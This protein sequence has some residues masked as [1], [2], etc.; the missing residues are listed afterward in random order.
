MVLHLAVSVLH[1]GELQAGW[2]PAGRLHWL[3]C[4]HPT[5]AP[6]PSQTPGEPP[7]NVHDRFA[8]AGALL[9]LL[10]AAL[11]ITLVQLLSAPAGK[12]HWLSWLQATQVPLLLQNPGV[13]LPV[14]AHP[15]F[16][17]AGTT[18]H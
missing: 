11:H 1:T 7:E 6:A 14:S 2:T 17:A 16:R 9:Q 3:L 13:E 12:L 8:I 5:H 4:R 15:V 18:L 10:V